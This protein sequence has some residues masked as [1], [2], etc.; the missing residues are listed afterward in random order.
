[1]ENFRGLSPGIFLLLY[2]VNVKITIFRLIRRVIVI[3]LWSWCNC[4]YRY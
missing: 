3:Q 4:K 1:M 2:V